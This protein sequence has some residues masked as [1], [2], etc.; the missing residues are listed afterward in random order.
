MVK[1][2]VDYTDNEIISSEVNKIFYDHPVP[3]LTQ[4]LK[5]ITLQSFTKVI[6]TPY[7]Y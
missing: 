1:P 3:I 7:Y 2:V 5:K 4:N 6:D